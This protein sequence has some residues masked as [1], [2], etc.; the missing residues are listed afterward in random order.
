[1]GTA[2]TKIIEVVRCYDCPFHLMDT[3]HYPEWVWECVADDEAKVVGKTRKR[4]LPKNCPL[5][6]DGI[7][8]RMKQQ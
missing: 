7:F 2:V 4:T 6:K 1:M 5:R 8:V 3:N